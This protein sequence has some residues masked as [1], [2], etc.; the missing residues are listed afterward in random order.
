M[1][2]LATLSPADIHRVRTSFDLMWPRSTEMADQ[3]YAR[4]FEIAPDSRALFRSD[5][6]RMKDKF[7]QTLA[8]LVGSLDNLTGLYA[9]A[10]KLAVDHV[11]YGVRPD[12]YAPVGEALLW[13]LGRQLAGFWNDDVEQSWRK[14]YAVISAR[15]IGAAYPDHRP[16]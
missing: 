10:G 16:A 12:H 14:V 4:L 2:P 5:M 9:V 13:S 6:T 1:S 3:F 15:M 8:V 11:R 7:I